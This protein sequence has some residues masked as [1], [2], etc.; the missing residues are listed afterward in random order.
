MVHE[1]SL[2]HK[3]AMLPQEVHH[4]LNIHN[5][6]WSLTQVKRIKNIQEKTTQQVVI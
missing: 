2:R 6:K 5:D 1:M 3:E 4:G